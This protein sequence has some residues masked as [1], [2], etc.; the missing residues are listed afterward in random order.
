MKE[1]KFK[2]F[3]CSG[4]D[5]GYVNEKLIPYIID[6]NILNDCIEFQNGINYTLNKHMI[7]NFIKNFI[8]K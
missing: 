6:N 7:K 3:Y 8:K 2:Q 5:I 4:T 1:N